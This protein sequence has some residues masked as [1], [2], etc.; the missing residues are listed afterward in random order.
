MLTVTFLVVVMFLYFFNYSSGINSSRVY[1]E[2][3]IVMI[4]GTSF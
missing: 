2:L 3:F 1:S 4:N